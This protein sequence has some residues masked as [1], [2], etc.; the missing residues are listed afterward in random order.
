MSITGTFSAGPVCVCV[1]GCMGGWVGVG[2]SSDE[3][4]DAKDHQPINFDVFHIQQASGETQLT[5]H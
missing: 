3:S 1:C 5:L 4:H 2:G